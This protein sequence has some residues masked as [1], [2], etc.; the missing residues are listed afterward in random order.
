M[1]PEQ[2]IH[3][4]L[5]GYLPSIHNFDHFGL[6]PF[7]SKERMAESICVILVIL[8]PELPAFYHV[9]YVKIVLAVRE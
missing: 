5:G 2:Y 9:I 3:V 1:F 6:L 7:L 8:L 4:P